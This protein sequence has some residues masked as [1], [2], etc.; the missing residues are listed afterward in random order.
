[1]AG[2]VVLGGGIS[3]ISAAYHARKAG[4][5]AVVYEAR[6]RWG[7]L[8]DHFTING[9]RFDHAVHFAFTD[10][11]Y[12]KEILYQ[13]DYYEH[14]PNPFNYEGGRWLKHPVQNNLYALP[15]E[16]RIEAI[17]SF[18]ERPALSP[19]GNY[20]EWLLQQYGE[21]IASRFPGTYTRKYWTVPAEELSVEWV[22]C[23]MYRPSLDE[24][25]FGA[26]TDKT[27]LT[28]YFKKMRYPKT[29]G[30]RA[31]LDPV[32]EGLD[33]RTGKRAVLVDPLKKYVCF[34]DGE[35]RFYDNLV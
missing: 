35:K 7:G 8:L 20:H 3:G 9:F 12:L 4:G 15:V 29:G 28:Y 33:I 13:V 5:K 18:V 31:F 17:K 30:F 23:R 32:V 26:M 1:M 19:A 27:P 10:D 2:L 22:G 16:E 6:D 14:D 24:V 34:E 21:V 11:P 25:L